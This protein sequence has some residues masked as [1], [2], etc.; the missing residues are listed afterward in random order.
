M[1]KSKKGELKSTKKGRGLE[2]GSNDDK[3]HESDES[4]DIDEFIPDSLSSS[5]D[6]DDEAHSNL[7]DDLID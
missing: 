6:D 3:A 1:Q 5:N 4:F 7:K 2:E